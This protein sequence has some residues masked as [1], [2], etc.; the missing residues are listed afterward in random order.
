MFPTVRRCV[1]FMTGNADSGPMTYIKAMVFTLQFVFVPY[2][3]NPGPEPLDRVS[4][5]FTQT[6]LLV[7]QYAEPITQLA[8]VHQHTNS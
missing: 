3:L 8:R 1:E 6:F 5:N 4:S 7:R 2:L